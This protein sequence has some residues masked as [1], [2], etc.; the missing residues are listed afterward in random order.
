MLSL[1]A[2]FLDSFD[3][4]V[5]NF[6]LY[7]T[8]LLLLM[9]LVVYLGVAI[10]TKFALLALLCVIISL[11]SIYIGFFVKMFGDKQTLICT[12]GARV[13]KM[14][15]FSNC[16]KDSLKPYFCPNEGECDAYYELHENAIGYQLAFPGLGSNIFFDSLYQLYGEAGNFV[17]WSIDREDYT[18]DIH[19]NKHISKHWIK[20][21]EKRLQRGN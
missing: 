19:G 7:G 14:G 1:Q 18:N 4:I 11:L 3:D 16:S 20:I 6:R 17:S 12:V 2:N 5:N 21:E 10:V 9:S 15:D 8:A 13:V